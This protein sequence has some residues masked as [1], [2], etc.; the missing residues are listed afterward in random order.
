M[1]AALLALTLTLAACEAAKVEPAATAGDPWTLQIV[2]VELVR[3]AHDTRPTAVSSP[4]SG[5]PVQAARG[6]L[7]VEGVTD[8]DGRWVVDLAGSEPYALRVSGAGAGVTVLDWPG[9]DLTLA[10]TPAAATPRVPAELVATDWATV[11]GFIEGWSSSGIGE[12]NV[13]R[14]AWRAEDGR[15]PVSAPA[16]DV[17]ALAA[18][19]GG[20]GSTVC[21]CS[22]PDDE[23]LC[24]SPGSEV[25]CVD[26]GTPADGVSGVTMHMPPGR[27]EIG[28]IERIYDQDSGRLLEIAAMS[29]DPVFGVPVEGRT[30]FTW[31]PLRLSNP[32]LCPNSGIAGALELRLRGLDRSYVLASRGGI[33]VDLDLVSPFGLAM[34]VVRGERWPAWDVYD[35]PESE[36]EQVVSL[37]YPFEL[38]GELD[39]FSWGYRIA[40]TSTSLP[41]DG[42]AV[43]RFRV[44]RAVPDGEPGP[45]RILVDLATAETTFSLP[46][47][48]APLR[49]EA[50]AIMQWRGPAAPLRR[51]RLT[52]PD[53]RQE[54]V[55]LLDPRRNRL[56]VSDPVASHWPIVP[57]SWTLGYAVIE[58]P[59]EIGAD[60]WL[61]DP[62]VQFADTLGA[63]FQQSHDFTVE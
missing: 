20:S 1:R 32:A 60:R 34:P 13:A 61:A 63:I 27:A 6:S 30:D 26:P 35:P 38:T 55:W 4:A 24:D 7:L 54:D 53:G 49:I 59:A 28:L 51:I 21:S 44:S 57:G 42:G 15:R 22:D 18:I 3:T 48:T 45:C 25:I 62:R 8:A 40:A 23:P 46:T 9:G 31:R 52:G 14:L 19:D 33:E 16:D 43:Y 36:S 58:P 47:T 5:L 2:Q 39:G 17:A 12:D 37:R 11:S 41:R 56:D 29:W 50:E 10:L